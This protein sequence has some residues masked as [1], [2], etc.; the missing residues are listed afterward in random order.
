MA[1]SKI[2]GAG[3]SADTLEAGDIAAGAIGTSEL[4]AD[5]VTGAELADNA[6]NSEHYTDVSID[7]AH[8]GNLQVTAAKVASDVA[9]TAGTQTFTNKT[10]TAP[11]LTTPALGTP[12]SGVVTN[13]SGV[14]PVGVPGGSGLTALGTVAS[15]SIGSG[16]TGLTG[17]K[18]VDTFRMTANMGYGN[19]GIFPTANYERLNNFSQ[20]DGTNAIIGGSTK[21]SVDT[22]TGYWTFPMTGVWQCIGHIAWY[23]YNTSNLSE[24]QVRVITIENFGSGNTENLASLS[25]SGSSDPPTNFRGRADVSIICDV[26]NVSTFRVMFRYSTDPSGSYIIAEGHGTVNYTWFQFI[27]LGDT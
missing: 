1:I 11:T 5:A 25:G 16:V 6:V 12:A 9:T 21:M 23:Q 7:T 22:S 8:L 26:T 27:R 13:L 24:C 3:V 14:L 15:G 20:G 10:L 19:G 4:A 2:P 18:I 17:V